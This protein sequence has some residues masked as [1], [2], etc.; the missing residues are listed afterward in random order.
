[1]GLFVAQD[2]Y[3]QGWLATLL[4]CFAA[5]GEDEHP[6]ELDRSRAAARPVVCR[7]QPQAVSSLP[8]VLTLPAQQQSDYH[9]PPS[10][11]TY[12]SEGPPSL[13]PLRLGDSSLLGPRPRNDDR[14]DSFGHAARPSISA[15]NA[16]RRLDF[17]EGQRAGLIPLR[18]G[19]VV[20][21]QSTPAPRESSITP[22]E[23]M[24]SAH[25]R[26]D[27]T[28]ELLPSAKRESYRQ[29]RGTPFQRC[30]RGSV[31]ALEPQQTPLATEEVRPPTLVLAT[32]SAGIARPQPSRQSS[33]S[34]LRRL[35]SEGPS[36]L[37][38]PGKSTERNRLRRKRSAQL[39]PKSSSDTFDLG[40]E[41]E[42]LELNTI[43][44]EKRA[45]TSRPKSP[46]PQHIAAIAPGMQVR[47]RSETLNDIGSALARPLTAREPSRIF[48]H[49][50]MSRTITRPSTAQGGPYTRNSSRVS[51]WLS[52]L[53]TTNTTPAVAGHELFYKCAPSSRPRPW[54]EASLCSTATHIESPSLTLASSLT[55]KTHSRSLTAES[56]I[57]TLSP[58]STVYDH[59]MPDIRKDAGVHW[60]LGI[61]RSQVGLAM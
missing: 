15:P 17:T 8:R 5:V 39:L 57:T 28:Q 55:S 10:S 7:T 4:C 33:S 47:A 13:Q 16:F 21:T 14:F 53:W 18:L 12:P 24:T 22:E 56:R 26:S 19:P 52:G 11:S 29:N 35:S 3:Y 6:A 1:M 9:E 46:E 59:E 27:S 61:T 45:D 30:Q 42:V 34:T 25:Q 37:E 32:S 44:E 54:S 50:V 51:G 49:E 20:L 48:D 2:G 43:V 23:R 58:P 60:P 40:I 41:K 38:G 31:V 36:P